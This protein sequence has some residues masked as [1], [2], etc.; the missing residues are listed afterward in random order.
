MSR[1]IA[2][3]L[4]LGACTPAQVPVGKR[5]G[6]VL[7][8]GGVGGLIGMAF[9]ERYTEAS[10]ELLAGFAVTSALGILLYAGIELSEGNVIYKAEPIPVRNR[11]WAKILSER[12]SGAARENRCARV[13]RL[14][15]RI[16]TYDR[17]IHDFVLLADPEVVRCL[18]DDQPAT[19]DPRAEETATPPFVPVLPGPVLPG[20]VLPVAPEATPD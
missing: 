11:R 13:R 9:A 2:L 17:E 12:A 5:V 19:L 16:A 7:A 1:A 15:R 6:Q 4:A 18:N 20:P 8:L 14:E 3:V 10:D